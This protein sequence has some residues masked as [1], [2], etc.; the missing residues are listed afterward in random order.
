MNLSDYD[1]KY[2][3]IKDTDGLAVDDRIYDKM[4]Y[5]YRRS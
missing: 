5:E 4:I 2:V 1:G 3:S